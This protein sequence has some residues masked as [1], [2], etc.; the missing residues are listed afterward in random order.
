M[1]KNLILLLFLISILLPAPVVAE[2][3]AGEGRSF[4][5][6]I[7]PF[8]G[9]E[10]IYRLYSPF[11]EYLNKTTG[12]SWRLKL[13]HSH[14]AV[15]NGIC[16]GEIDIALLG[17][18]PLGRAHKRCRVEPLLVLLDRDGAPF[19]RSVMIAPRDGVASLAD[20][21]GRKV[22]FIQGSTVAH[23]VPLKML[24]EA[25]VNMKEVIP[26]FYKNQVQIVNAV[27][28]KEVAAAGIK[29]ALYEKIKND[30]IKALKFSDPVPNLA[31][32][33][34]PSIDPTAR[35]RFVS[36]LE[37]LRPLKAGPDSA[38]VEDWDEEI[39]YGFI[40]PPKTFLADALK[41]SGAYKEITHEGR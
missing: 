22:G 34:A 29:E 37:K 11:I 1:G 33:A 5:V 35:N 32:C 7:I 8:Y 21:K 39:K 10:K 6:A 36:A 19:Y 30:A 18:V 41:L 31:F 28:K 27:L 17:P 24:E 25:G 23:V 12:L 3:P 38:L 16:T 20:L 4:D 9:P 15:I 40:R 13:Y 14:E 2:R 26:V